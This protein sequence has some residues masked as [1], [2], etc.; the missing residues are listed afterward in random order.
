MVAAGKPVKTAEVAEPVIL[1]PPGCAVTVHAAFGKPLRSTLPV[2]TLQVGGVI[3]PT[4]GAEGVTGWAGITAPDEDAEL[5]PDD[6]KVTEKVCVVLA[7][8]PLNV[9]V[10]V[11]PLITKPLGAANTVQLLVGKLLRAT[12]PVDTLQVGGVT[13]PTVGTCGVTG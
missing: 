13:V 1:K 5:Q 9:A 2:D 3:M 7:G 4:T 12:L 11:L 8:N 6:N 10:A